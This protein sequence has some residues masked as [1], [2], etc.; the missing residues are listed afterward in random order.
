LICDLILG[1]K[2]KFFDFGSQSTTAPPH[3]PYNS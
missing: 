3:P 2:R 1:S